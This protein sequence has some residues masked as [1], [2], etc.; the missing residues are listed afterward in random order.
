MAK[1]T[2]IYPGAVIGTWR[3]ISTESKGATNKEI[4][5][6]CIVCGSTRIMWNTAFRQQRASCHGC[7][8]PAGKL[9]VKLSSELPILAVCPD[10]VTIC[11]GDD[12]IPDNTVSLWRMVS[13]TKA[14]PC[15]REDLGRP[16]P[17]C[18]P[19]DEGYAWHITVPMAYA[20]YYLGLAELSDSL[21]GVAKTYLKNLL[22]FEKEDEYSFFFKGSAVSWL[23][24]GIEHCYI[25]SRDNKSWPKG[26]PKPDI[27]PV[28]LK[29][30]D[31]PEVEF[32]PFAS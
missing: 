19:P 3:I 10:K 9:N 5:C 26:M 2:T 11:Y 27:A 14:I 32:N 23:S 13:A 28:G 17:S 21:Q 22:E 8:S 16:E 6:A 24:N 29:V 20:D 31:L 30:K 15:T 4:L 18:P 12:T 7:S 1:P 25:Y